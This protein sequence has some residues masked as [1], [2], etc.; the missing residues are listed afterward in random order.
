MLKSVT[1]VTLF[2]CFASSKFLINTEILIS[3][4]INGVEVEQT[5]V[6]RVDIP[7]PPNDTENVLYK[8]GKRE[9]GKLSG[10]KSRKISILYGG[11]IVVPTYWWEIKHNSFA[12][13]Q[14]WIGDRRLTW[15]YSDQPEG[16]QITKVNNTMRIPAEGNDSVCVFRAMELLIGQV[17]IT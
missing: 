11:V 10:E 3:Y 8:F 5:F 1:L 7:P 15:S 14:S 4:Q 6:S 12:N 2:V 13:E 9:S 17:N 16:S